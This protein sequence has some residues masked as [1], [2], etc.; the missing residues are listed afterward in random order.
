M[1]SYIVMQGETYREEK[2]LGIVRAP[3]KDKSGATPHSWERVNSL[4]KGDRTFHYVRGALVAVGTIQEDARVQSEG[5]PQ[6][7][8]LAPCEY[9]ELDTPLEIA[10][11]IKVVADYLPL[12]YSAFQPDG[13]G[14]SGYVFP[15]NESL[16]L[17]FLELL[18]SSKWRNIEQLEFVYDAVREEKYNSLTA[19]MMDSEYLLRLKFRELKSQFKALQLERWENKCAICG[20]DNLALLKAVYSKAWKD[21]ND[22]E[23]IDPANGVLLCANH[24]ALYESGQISFTGA[25]TLR[26]SAELQPLA[27]RYGLKKNL[28]IAADE[29]NIPYFRWH[30]NNF[31]IEE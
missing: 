18:S 22:A 28:R 29:A 5:T 9:L 19:W 21:S 23:R 20:L 7:E 26:M 24:A 12:K 2:R 11:C 27:G 15:C 30:R 14:N 10:S 8:W 13:N 4:Q 3:K 16:A 6:A 17:V 25:G 1:N 31:F